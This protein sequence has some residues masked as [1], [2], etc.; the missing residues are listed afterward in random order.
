MP[1]VCVFGRCDDCYIDAS[2]AR[3]E[4]WIGAFILFIARP[5]PFFTPREH[6]FLILSLAS[7]VCN[8]IICALYRATAIYIYLFIRELSYDGWQ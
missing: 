7:R 1:C 5:Q 2:P 6:P 8:N 3:K 4:R